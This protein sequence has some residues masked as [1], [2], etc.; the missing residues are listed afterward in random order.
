MI[1]VLAILAL[2]IGLVVPLLGQRGSG[3][4]L[5]AATG[6]IRT[7]MAEARALAIAEGR[8]VVFRGDSAGGYWLDN[9]HRGVDAEAGNRLRVLTAGN[10]LIAF[11]PSG[12]S[13]GGRVVVSGPYSR[14]EIV[15]DGVT[16]RAV[17]SP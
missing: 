7:A 2:A 6:R 15:V 17:A 13:S 1:V 4:E 9:R 12:G 5:N 11:F 3:A 8:P 10:A 14:R 16:G